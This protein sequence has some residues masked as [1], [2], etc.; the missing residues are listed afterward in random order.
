[1]WVHLVSVVDAARLSLGVVCGSPAFTGSEAQRRY[2]SATRAARL[3]STL[4]PTPSQQSTG[5]TSCL[6]VCG[7]DGGAPA[8]GACA[9]RQMAVY[10]LACLGYALPL[11]VQFVM[12][13]AAR[14]KFYRRCAMPPGRCCACCA[15]GVCC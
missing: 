1:V 9:C 10:A 14:R 2:A 6:D 11:A 5:G 4:A 8:L 15:G 13:A 7:G 12:E 3:L